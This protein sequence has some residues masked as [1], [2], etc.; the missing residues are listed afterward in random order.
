MASKKTDMVAKL[1]NE[2]GLACLLNGEDAEA[3]QS[4]IE[5]FCGGKTLGI[6]MT[7]NIIAI[8]HN[9]PLTSESEPPA[10]IEELCCEEETCTEEEAYTEE[11]SQ[12][13]GLLWN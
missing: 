12:S 13:S 4:F 6:R 2:D 9:E 7:V 11:D 3:T 5:V 1:L 10:C 8:T